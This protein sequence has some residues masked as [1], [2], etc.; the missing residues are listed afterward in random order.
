MA[1][2]KLPGAYF[3]VKP[4]PSLPPRP[5]A[6]TDPSSAPGVLPFLE[7]FIHRITQ[8]KPVSG[9]AFFMQP[10]GFELQACCSVDHQSVPF[11]C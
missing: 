4:A 1:P 9:L 6:I 2:K 5:Q 3:V 10:D 11:Y 8:Y 7:R